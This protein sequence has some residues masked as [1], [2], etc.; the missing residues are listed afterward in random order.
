METTRRLLGDLKTPSLIV[1][2][3]YI[4]IWIDQ[5]EEEG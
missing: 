2:S 1:E 3:S 4:R 5:S